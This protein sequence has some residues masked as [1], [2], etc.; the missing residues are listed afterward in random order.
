MLP[1]LPYEGG[2][3]VPPEGS[4]TRR[5]RT[6]CHVIHAG[7]TGGGPRVL[8]DAV[9][10][11]GDRGFRNVVVCGADGPLAADLLRADVLTMVLTHTGKWS[12]ALSV[13]ALVRFLRRERIDVV[14]LYGQFA[15]FYGA[16]ASRLAG[17]PAIYEAHF[18][19]FV[20]DTSLVNRVRN[21]LVEWMSCRLTGATTVVSD[22][23]RREYIR[24]R[25]QTPEHLYL[26]PNGV[27]LRCAPPDEVWALRLNLLGEGNLLLVAAG[28]MEHQ[29]GFDVLLSAMPSVMQAHPGVRLALVGEGPCRAELDSLLTKL[30]LS[31]IV[32]IHDFQRPLDPWL[33][34]ADAVAV[35]SRYENGGISATGA[36]PLVG[37]G[38]RTRTLHR[39]RRG[40]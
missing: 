30:D 15:G 18:P 28:R 34:A 2:K 9:Q 19:S 39:R 29:K 10:V 20:T 7:V 36:W 26:V 6:I 5:D 35:P 31:D 22:A 11:S 23:D 16:I 1:S 13:P 12:F 27:H 3:L 14:L 33:Q 21:H 17:V 24:R 40:R 38:F 25:L 32:T 4:S 37:C 8:M